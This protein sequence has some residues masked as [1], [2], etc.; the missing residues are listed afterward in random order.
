LDADDVLAG[1]GVLFELA[2][3]LQREQPDAL[4]AGNLQVR[5]GTVLPRPNRATAD[6]LEPGHL[7]E[8]LHRMATGDPSA[9]L[10]SC[11]TVVRRGLSIRY[12]VVPS[13]EDHWYTATLLLE[14]GRLRV[15]VAPHLLYAIYRLRGGLTTQ[16]QASEHYLGSRRALAAFARERIEK[17]SA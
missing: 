8:R 11:N 17:R 4:I 10:P 2:T 3:I 7:V 14:H 9:E 15:A 13:A 12:P 6:L 1:P 5:D 16:N